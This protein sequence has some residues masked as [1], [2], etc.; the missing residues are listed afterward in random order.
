MA[1]NGGTFE[2]GATIMNELYNQATGKQ[3]LAPVNTSEF[4]SMAT[5][6]QKVM[7]DQL[8]GWITQMIDRTIF[9]M[10]PLPEQTLGLEV[11]EQKWGNQVRKLTPVY[12]EKF[13]TD[14]SRLPLISTQ[15]NGGAYG[16]G[17][18]MFKVKTR[19]ILQTNFYGGN[20]F[21]NY[22]TYFRD[23]LNQAFRSPD[24]LA[25]YI[26]MLTIDR[27]NYLNLSKKVTAQACLNNFIGAKL[28]S[29]AEEKNRIHLLTEY[30]AIA[31]TTLTYDTVFAPDNFRP[32]MMWVK[33]RIETI[34]ALMT[35]GSTLFHTNIT[36]KPVMRHTPYKNQKAWIYAPMDRMLDSEVLSNLFNTEYMKLIDHRRVNYW[37]NIEKPGTINIEPSIMG[38][39]GTITKVSEAVNEDHVFGVIADED[40]L[41]ISLISHW[42][43]T[44]PFNSRGG[45]YTMWEHWTV[46]Y[47]NDLTE[48]G[49][50]LLLD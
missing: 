20:R 30:N 27:R 4:I 9:S 5:T 38:V 47:W 12:D 8:G 49:V 19:Q 46:R 15:E 17:V 1:Q 45:Y 26:Q 34:C 33:A 23:Q 35:E 21:E 31:G 14:D 3:T 44:T 13:Y 42:T 6:V 28:S 40:A 32:F 50:V 2:Q 48:N 22:L 7:E 29:D 24:E 41:G 37:Q 10:R 16:D 36:N 39:D 25:R 18:D 11:S 43:S